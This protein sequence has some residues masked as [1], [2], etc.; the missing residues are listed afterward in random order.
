MGRY[1]QN[2]GG[3]LGLWRL[4]TGPAVQEG[5]RAACR[6]GPIGHTD[7]SRRYLADVLRYPAETEFL[8]DVSDSYLESR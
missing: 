4:R 8:L 7:E 3:A 1:T 2:R 6:H 5:L